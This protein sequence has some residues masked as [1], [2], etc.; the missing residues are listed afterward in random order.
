MR[1]V[2]YLQIE[3][4]ETGVIAQSKE[5]LIDRMIEIASR[6]PK[7]QDKAAVRKA[8]FD[9]EHIMSTGIG[10][11]CA[12]PHG[13]CDAV[14]DI[15]IALGIT[16]EPVDYQSLDGNPVQI[17]LLMVRRESDNKLRLVLLSHAS[18]VLNAAST[19]EALLH[20]KTRREI[21]DIIQREE[22]KLEHH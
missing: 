16:A 8:V 9:R 3:C 5:E 17:V 10:H 20:A 2:D 18:K 19:R 15:I 21:F 7:L 14:D 11:A 13:K 6:N 22:E 4:I 1:L 12:V